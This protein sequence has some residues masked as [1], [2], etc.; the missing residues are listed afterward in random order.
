MSHDLR[1]TLGY[2]PL[3]AQD[4]E[5]QR[6]RDE[7]HRTKTAWASTGH[8]DGTPEAREHQKID[9]LLTEYLWRRTMATIEEDRRK[10]P[11][12]KRNMPVGSALPGTTKSGKTETPNIPGFTQPDP[13]G[14]TK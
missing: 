4:A 2:R 8:Q 6:L 13:R 1:G 9:R 12:A 14:I 5:E 11:K 7:W 3:P 10:H